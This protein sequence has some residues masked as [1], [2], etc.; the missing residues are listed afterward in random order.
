M[1]R[2]PEDNRFGRAMLPAGTGARLLFGNVDVVQSD[3]GD[4]SVPSLGQHRLPGA[5]SWDQ[6]VRWSALEQ[7]N[8]RGQL[9]EEALHFRWLGV[10]PL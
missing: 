7:I 9:A 5:R 8:V 1:L 2:V 6:K 4:T 3:Y 10:F